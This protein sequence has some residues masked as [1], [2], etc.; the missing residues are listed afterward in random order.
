M[1]VE[2]GVEGTSSN[3]DS[4]SA[5]KRKHDE[6]MAGFEDVHLEH[7]GKAVV[8]ISTE[9][10]RD[11]QRW[12]SSMPS[13]SSFPHLTHLDLHKNRYITELD[14]SV[15]TLVHLKLL[16]LSQCSK[17][18]R[19]PDKIGD[20]KNLEVVSRQWQSNALTW[21]VNR[22]LFKDHTDLSHSPSMMPTTA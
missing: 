21:G 4:S 14:S 19:L 2:I 20:L 6:D 22:C 3:M 8:A 16:K 13:L 1:I 12:Q 7:E 17:L 5:R 9:D 18:G 10:T 15:T 11:S